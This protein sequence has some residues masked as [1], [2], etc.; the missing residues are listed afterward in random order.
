M[1]SNVCLFLVVSRISW[2][3]MNV[4]CF[5]LSSV[6]CFFGIL[7][8]L[9]FI[10][11]CFDD[12]IPHL[13]SPS[14]FLAHIFVEIPWP[15]GDVHVRPLFSHR[16]HFQLLIP[17]ATSCRSAG[18]HLSRYKAKHGKEVVQ[19]MKDWGWGWSDPKICFQHFCMAQPWNIHTIKKT[20]LKGKA[21]GA[22]EVSSISQYP[23]FN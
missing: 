8:V 16:F 12:L 13:S 6:Y 5:S 14:R 20:E 7:V 23:F 1:S 22:Q 18:L 10:L 21:I 15:N 19:R 4:P 11:I 9:P 17:I 3:L 2:N